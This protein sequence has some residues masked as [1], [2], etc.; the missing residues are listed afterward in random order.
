MPKKYAVIS[1]VAHPNEIYRSASGTFRAQRGFLR[2]ER[3]A[4]SEGRME[5]PKKFR[6]SIFVAAREFQ[7]FCLRFL[8]MRASVF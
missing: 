7:N 8:R 5:H 3:A 6:G 1:V 4:N 2:H